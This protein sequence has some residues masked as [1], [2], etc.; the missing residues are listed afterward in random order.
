MMKIIAGL[1]LAISLNAFADEDRA[2]LDPKYPSLVNPRVT[3]L[4]NKI[5]VR[6]DTIG[7]IEDQSPVRSQEAR[8]TC[9]I[10]SATAYLEGLMIQAK[11]ADTKINLSEEWLQYTAV[12]GKT[13]DGSYASVNFAAIKN[14]GM[15]SEA[16]LPYIGVDWVDNEHPLKASR[17]G[18]LKGSK[19]TACEVVHFDPVLLKK[20]D[21]ELADS[22]SGFYSPEILM[23]R[24]EAAEFKGKY[25]RDNSR[26]FGVYDTAD[27][28]EILLKGKAVVLEVDFYY[29][30]WN[31]RG[32]ESLGIIRKLDEWSK[33]I[34]TSPVAGSLDLA[35]SPTK[36]AGHSVLI[37]GY[38]DEKIVE[39]NIQ[40]VDGTIK[41]VKFKGVYYLKNSWGSADFGKN[42]EIEG[43]KFPGYGMMVQD[44]A[45]NYGQF[46]MLSI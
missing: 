32:G 23:A 35:K 3:I 42:F 29:G 17:C 9:S 2:F 26:A 8:G 19:K 16:T 27:I 14:F 41:K 13:S 10:F 20:T 38:D 34:I 11:Y 4:K 7:V 5:A 6:S 12:G 44:Y 33:G 25:I 45:H 24:K 28:K 22:A 36:P 39:S 30:A 21:V 43:K 15:A 31:H 46:Y 40:M 1:T 18:A 37:V